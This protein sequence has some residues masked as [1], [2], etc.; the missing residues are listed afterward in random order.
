[1]KLNKIILVSVFLLAIIS[2]G[3]VSAADDIT[4]DDKLAVETNDEVDVDLDTASIDEISSDSD[5]KDSVAVSDDVNSVENSKLGASQI[6]VLK[7]PV[8][9]T[10]TIDTKEIKY[11]QVEIVTVTIP[12]ATGI[13]NITCNNVDYSGT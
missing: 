5:F 1:M 12:N 11:G 7:D 8:D 10:Y 9:P 6:D 3:A 2:L 13:V 4:A